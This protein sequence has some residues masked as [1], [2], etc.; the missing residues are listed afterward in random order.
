M[1]QA[2]ITIPFVI[3]FIYIIT[4][5]LEQDISTLE[6]NTNYISDKINLANT[7]LVQQD[8]ELDENEPI[9][10]LPVIDS[11]CKSNCP[12]N[13]KLCIYMCL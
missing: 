8:G 3:T 13:F 10:D 6:Q 11:P 5:P 7:I 9:T 1:N 2:A 4:L 12:P